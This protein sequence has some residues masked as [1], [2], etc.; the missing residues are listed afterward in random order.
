LAI[1]AAGLGAGC[2]RDPAPWRRAALA[3]LRGSCLPMRS[4]E[5]S[6]SVGFSVGPPTNFG[7]MELGLATSNRAG[8]RSW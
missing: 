6:S 2:L 7:G 5:S 1:A 3:L 8:S 4:C